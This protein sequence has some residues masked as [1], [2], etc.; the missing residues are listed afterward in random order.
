MDQTYSVDSPVRL[1]WLPCLGLM[2]CLLLLAFIARPVEAGWQDSLEQRLNQIDR[3]YPGELGVYVQDLESGDSVSLRDNGQWYLASTVKVPVAI[4]VL[5]RV[6]EG[7]LSLDDKIELQPADFVDGAGRTNWQSPGDR[8]SVRKLFERMLINSDNTATDVLI[9]VVGLDRIN[10]RFQQIAGE[11]VGEIT[12]LAD[13]RRYAYR[14]F[15]QGAMKLTSDDF[16]ALKKAD[17]DRGRVETLARLLGVAVSDF[18]VDG[19]DAAFDQ[20]Y[21]TGRNSAHLSHFS[22]IW[23][24]IARGDVLETDTREYLIDT[25]E[26]I[27]TGDNRIKAGL[28]EGISFAHKTGTQHRRACNI[29]FATANRSAAQKR[30]I[31]AVCVRGTSDLMASERA[32][33]QVGEAVSNSGVLK[34]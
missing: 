31:I 1:A 25:L 34:F 33:R 5:E 15:H 26:N 13:V 18:R 20:Y 29:G 28:P 27:R 9:R 32:M 3:D 7:R 30:V 19:L 24:A 17:G 14:N 4:S 12:T 11:G 16:F 10:E 21:Q 6:D 23:A 2:A 22:R 8:V